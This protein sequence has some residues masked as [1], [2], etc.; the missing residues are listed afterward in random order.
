MG[1]KISWLAISGR[2]KADVLASLDLVDTG[3]RDEAN[4]SPI[5]VAEFPGDWTV[6][7]LNSF[8]HPL[9][10]E[11]FL[12]ELSAGCTVIV[13]QVHEGIMYCSAALYE[14][15]RMVW[16]VA[17]DAQEDRYHLETEGALPSALTDIREHLKQKQDIEG[18]ET[19]PVD[20]IFNVPVDLAKSICG[21]EYCRWRYDWGEPNFTRA[22][23]RTL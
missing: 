14:N 8:L 6:L 4:E 12:S 2:S 16:G 11:A 5:S 7:F 22:A 21:F 23:E 19:A 13:G 3:E 10:E 18:G 17:H 15:G 20:Y 9:T 1:F